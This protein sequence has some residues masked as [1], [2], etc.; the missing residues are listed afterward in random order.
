MAR[1]KGRSLSLSIRVSLLLMVAAI[2]PL[3][4]TVAVSE[5]LTRSTLVAQASTAMETDV[6]TRVQLIDAYFTERLLDVE[7]ISRV[8]DVQQFFVD[9]AVRPD[10]APSLATGLL[11][12]SQRDSHYTTWSLFDMEG[13]LLISSPSNPHPHG[14]YLVPPDDL[15]AVTSGKP[16]ISTVFFDPVLRKA[17]VDI[18][19]PII[20]FTN[21]QLLGFVRATLTMDYVLNIVSNNSGANGTG[22]YAFI[23]D[24]NGVRIAYPRPALQFTAIAPLTPQIQQQISKEE[25]YG[26]AAT[27]PIL[28]DSGLAKIQQNPR[29]PATFQIILSGDNQSSQVALHATQVVPWMYFV[30]SPLSTV[31]AVA[32][33]QLQVTLLIALLILIPA[34]GAGLIVGRLITRPILKAVEHIRSNSQALNTLAIK[35]KS[36]AKEQTW[37]V[38]S[39]G[40]GL[41]SVQ[42]YSEAARVATQQ[43]DEKGRN[44]VQYWEMCNRQGAKQEVIKLLNINEYVERAIRYQAESNQKLATALEVTTQVTEQLASGANSA[45]EASDQLEQVVNQLHQVVGK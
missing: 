37:V 5:P 30:V 16:F 40:V 18:Y 45:T 31:T 34:A 22:S 26:A 19:A 13:N 35:Q 4:I 41:E 20:S 38:N 42:Y 12:G 8:P 33:Q 21:S 24:Q 36:A 2:L 23:L 10:L 1:Q 17:C 28:G 14:Q 25:R 29:P 11:A 6:R 15:H 9:P 3:L 44:L 7:T 39:S 43:L 27:V 32:D